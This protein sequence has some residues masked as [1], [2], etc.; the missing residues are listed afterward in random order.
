MNNGI[1]LTAAGT[2][3]TNGYGI[4]EMLD[5]SSP[6]LTGIVGLLTLVCQIYI[7]VRN[8][9]KQRKKDKQDE[10]NN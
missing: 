1:V 2:A 6:T 4:T 8:D 5:K 3:V 9:L 10:A 7:M